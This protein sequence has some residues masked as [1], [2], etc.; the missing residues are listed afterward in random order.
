MNIGR[1]YREFTIKLGDD[2]C[3]VKTHHD[4]DI[5][6]LVIFRKRCEKNSNLTP[7]F[8]Y[9][10][11]DYSDIFLTDRDAVDYRTFI[12][13]S[14]SDL[15]NGMTED[16][17]HLLYRKIFDIIKEKTTIPVLDDWADYIVKEFFSRKLISAC[18]FIKYNVNNDQTEESIVVN[19]S[20]YKMILENPTYLLLYILYH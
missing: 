20:D 13:D 18:T 4:K 16:R 12:G 7:Y 10:D 9:L 19:H 1:T 11:E 6:H 5:G 17:S 15:V 3:F 8:L 2:S 14:I